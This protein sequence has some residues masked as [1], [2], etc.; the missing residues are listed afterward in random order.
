VK[1]IKVGTIQFE[2]TVR[3]ESNHWW[4]MIKGIIVRIIIYQWLTLTIK[5]KT[6]Q[7]YYAF[8]V[9]SWWFH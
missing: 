3:N 1:S 8:E 4:K 7:W 9:V 2:F 6:S 5:K